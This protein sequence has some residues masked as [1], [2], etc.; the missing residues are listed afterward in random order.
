MHRLDVLRL[1]GGWL[2][3]TC[4]LVAGLFLLDRGPFVGL[5]VASIA[6]AL[7]IFWTLVAD[8]L[9]PGRSI[10]LGRGL[11]IVAAGAVVAGGGWSLWLVSTP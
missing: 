10:W 11:E 8:R 6:A 7:G 1:V 9:C 3:A 4:L 5:A 2:W